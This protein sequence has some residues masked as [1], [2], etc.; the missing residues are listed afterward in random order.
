MNILTYH[1]NCIFCFEWYSRINDRKLHSSNCDTSYLKPFL[2]I[3]DESTTRKWRLTHLAALDSRFKF[4]GW[5]FMMLENRLDEIRKMKR[6]N[7]DRT[8]RTSGKENGDLCLFVHETIEL[9]EP[10]FSWTCDPDSK[11]MCVARASATSVDSLSTDGSLSTR[12]NQ[13][14]S[15]IRERRAKPANG[16]SCS[17][18][19]DL[20]E[21]DERTS[22]WSG[23]EF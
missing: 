18:R 1:P 8:S 9:S 7:S 17:P 16:R 3:F 20:D 2:E 21:C 22:N 12:S 5:L 4:Q 6:N 13:I 23:Q 11:W 15:L 19:D 10:H 14:R